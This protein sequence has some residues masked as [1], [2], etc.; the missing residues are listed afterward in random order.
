MMMIVMMMTRLAMM[1]LMMT[2]LM[3]MNAREGPS[4]PQGG[5]GRLREAL[6]EPRSSQGGQE[7]SE[8]GVRGQKCDR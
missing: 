7:R 6:R 2:M 5:P 8:G 3:T 4:R 1:M